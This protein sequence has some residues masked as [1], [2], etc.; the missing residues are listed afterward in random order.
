MPHVIVKLYPGRTEAQKQRLS[1]EIARNVVEILGCEDRVVSVAFEEV[2][3]S[4]WP[5]TVYRPDILEKEHL[6]YK[7]PG[8]NPFD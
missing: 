7:K 3:Q 2:A 5:E 1:A 4:A 6:L 8:Y